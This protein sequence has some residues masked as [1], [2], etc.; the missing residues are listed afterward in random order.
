MEMLSVESVAKNADYQILLK[1]Q[2]AW[3]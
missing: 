1:L 2:T 3:N